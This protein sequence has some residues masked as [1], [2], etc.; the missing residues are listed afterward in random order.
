MNQ[1]CFQVTQWGE[2]YD[3]R[4]MYEA[5]GIDS[6]TTRINIISIK[7]HAVNNIS[8]HNIFPSWWRD[9][10][11]RKACICQWHMSIFNQTLSQKNIK[12]YIFIYIYQSECTC[13]SLN[14]LY[15]IWL[16]W[17]SLK[18]RKSL[19]KSFL[20]YDIKLANTK[21]CCGTLPNDLIGHQLRILVRM[22]I[23]V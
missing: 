23:S 9:A 21:S 11:A 1:P 17:S 16:I 20:G 6:E 14:L 10:M 18:A 13:I 19:G 3:I 8:Y 5:K 22:S 4:R 7:I 2:R 15:Y 12:T